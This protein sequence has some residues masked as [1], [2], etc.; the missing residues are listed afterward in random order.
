MDETPLPA[1]L[2]GRRRRLLFRA[3]HR[4][5]KEADILVGGFVA[6]RIG[7]FS[8]AELDVLEAIMDLPDPELADWLTGRLPIP[9]AHAQAPMLLA[10]R[11]AAG[12]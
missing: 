2:D 5:T 8:G 1:P 11:Q 3:S 7:G 10:M 9:A 4:G 12:Q 6:A